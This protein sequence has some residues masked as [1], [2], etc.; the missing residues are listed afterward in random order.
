MAEQSKSPPIYEIAEIDFEDGRTG[1]RLADYKHAYSGETIALFDT[2]VV[3][4][5]PETTTFTT[6]PR[7]ITSTD[8]GRWILRVYGEKRRLKEADDFGEIRFTT[9][10]NSFWIAHLF[11]FEVVEDEGIPTIRDQ[12]RIKVEIELSRVLEKS[13]EDVPPNFDMRLDTNHGQFVAPFDTGEWHDSWHTRWRFNEFNQ[14]GRRATAQALQYRTERL[15][16][17][18]YDIYGNDG[19]ND[20]AGDEI[21]IVVNDYIPNDREEREWIDIGEEHFGEIYVPVAGI[22]NRYTM[23]ELSIRGLGIEDT[24]V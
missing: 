23:A 16:L 4:E 22:T 7:V 1:T 24:S 8:Y 13:D 15:G 10:G 20:P 6:T 3:A 5:S 18:Y 12:E 11:P 19:R 21:I 9:E 2:A 14:L 17:S